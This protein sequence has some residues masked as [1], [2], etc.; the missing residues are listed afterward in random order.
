[1]EKSNAPEWRRRLRILAARLDRDV[2]DEIRFHIDEQVDALVAA[3]LDREG[4]EAEAFRMFGNV[5]DIEN[6]LLALRRQRESRMSRN[7]YLEDFGQDIRLAVRGLRKNPLFALVTITVLALGIGANTAVFGVVDAALIKPLPFPDGGS[8]VYIWD[9]RDGGGRGP[10]AYPEFADWQR[11]NDFLSAIATA[12]TTHSTYLGDLGPERISL[13]ALSGDYL[14]VTGL[15]PV[16]G[17]ALT[18]ADAA[19]DE[20]VAM[21]SE[22]FWRSRFGGRPDALGQTLNVG[23]RPYTIVGVTPRKASLLLEAEDIPV[24]TPFRDTQRL[25]RG[26]HFLVVVG[27]VGPGLTLDAAKARAEVMAQGLRDTDVTTHGLVLET[28]RERLVGDRQ[29]LLF[30]LAGAVG[31]LLLIVCANLATLFLSQSTRRAREFSIRTAL[32]AGRLRLGRQVVTESLLLGVLGGAVGFA[33]SYVAAGLVREAAGAAAA[34]APTTGVE[35]RIIVFTAALSLI[36]ALLFGLGP[37]IRAS[38][39]DVAETLKQS[40][41]NRTSGGRSASRTRSLLVTAEIALS[42]V[43][44]AGAGLMLKSVTRLLDQDPGFDS[45]NVLSLR[46]SLPR[47]HYS[48]DE[49]IVQFYDELLERVRALPGVDDASAVSQL[50]LGGSDTNGTFDIVGREYAPDDDG[51]RAQKR[52][53]SAGYFEAMRIP[54]IRGRTFTRADARSDAPE[55]AIISRT[56]A[57]RYWPAEDPIGRQVEFDWGPGDVQEVIGVVGDVRNLELDAEPLGAIYVPRN[58]FRAR[59]MTLVVRATSDPLALVRPI[60]AAVEAIDPEQPIYSIMTLETVMRASVATRRTFMFLLLG[61]AFVA[62]ILAIVGVYA[63]TAQSVGQRTQEM[64]VRLAI[65]AEPW[66]VLRMVVGEELRIIVAGLLLGLAGALAVT[67]LLSS[68][69]FEVSAVDPATFVTVGALLGVAAL[70]A[71]FVPARRAAATD[72]ISALRAE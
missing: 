8:I 54:L 20:R 5:T 37:A 22:D 26:L 28:V 57:E 52:I 35:P 2:E 34:F 3:G 63:I 9:G 18:A 59:G 41:S 72:P 30:L 62:L 68:L 15:G 31:F 69:L 40:A 46:I 7:R 71:A 58:Q 53:A 49:R 64:G 70:V 10:V 36:A 50:P 66:R 32:G 48:E 67:R 24:W 42:L 4:A 47:A 51:P 56:V 23:G 19:A 61:F 44:L 11:E 6:Q 38:G 55:V 29:T 39:P 16:I 27:R 45:R 60:R 21:I 43:L 33:L 25:T 13:T 12:Y 1:M 17:R 65:G 14:K